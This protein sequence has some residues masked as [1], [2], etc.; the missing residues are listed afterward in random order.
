MFP[1]RDKSRVSLASTTRHEAWDAME[2]PTTD[3]REWLSTLYCIFQHVSV[4]VSNRYMIKLEAAKTQPQH[5]VGWT[6]RVQN[7]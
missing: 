1:V 3:T 6:P 4:K 5:N 7:I 2:T